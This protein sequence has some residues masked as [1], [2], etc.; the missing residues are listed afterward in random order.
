MHTEGEE[1]PMSYEEN[2]LVLCFLVRAV[3]DIGKRQRICHR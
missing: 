2:W 3:E 1:K